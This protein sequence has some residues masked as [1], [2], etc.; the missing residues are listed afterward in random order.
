MIEGLFAIFGERIALTVPPGGLALWPRFL[1]AKRLP[2]LQRALA[3]RGVRL[4][5]GRDFTSD[6]RPL[7]HARVG[8]A[9]HDDRER[10]VLLERLRAA[11]RSG[12]RA[13]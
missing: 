10:A 6:A 1:E 2:A 7:P 13:R 8:F 4:D 9:F 5:I 12:G 11:D 3:T